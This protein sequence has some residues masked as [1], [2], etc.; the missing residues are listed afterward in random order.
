MAQYCRYCVFCFEGDGF[1]CSDPS[2]DRNKP[3]KYMDEAEIKRVNH[4]QN[5]ALSELGDVLSGR[6][7][8]PRQ[9]KVDDGQISMEDYL[10]GRMERY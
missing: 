1:F 3:L 10:N 9:N 7:Y 5:F 6:Q 4:C 2:K 8:K